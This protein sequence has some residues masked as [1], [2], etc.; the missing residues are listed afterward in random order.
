MSESNGLGQKEPHE[1]PFFGSHSWLVTY[2]RPR[3]T[4]STDEAIEGWF[5][6]I[7]DILRGKLSLP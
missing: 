7:I 2:G 5:F 1:A 3:P 6:V 4:P